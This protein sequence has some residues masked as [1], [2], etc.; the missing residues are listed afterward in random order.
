MG[1][2]TFFVMRVW[3]GWFCFAVLVVAW[4]VR[5]SA[6][7]GAEGG[8]EEG[9]VIAYIPEHLQKRVPGHQVTHQA[10]APLEL[11]EPEPD[12]DPP[13]VR[14]AKIGIWVSTVGLLAGTGV[15]LAGATVP[16]V[17]VGDP[18]SSSSSG[19]DGVLV[20]GAVIAVT[21]ALSMI[22]TGILLGVRKRKHRRGD[23]ASRSRGVGEHH[24]AGW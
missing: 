20:A 24:F 9:I 2:R 6:D 17:S 13:G 18:S 10:P 7:V 19:N 15:L 23:Q 8:S 22:A 21:S 4:P 12:P 16:D 14:N 3:L 5:G 11:E 1:G